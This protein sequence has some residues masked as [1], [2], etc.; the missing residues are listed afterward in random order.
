[1]SREIVPKIQV[2]TEGLGPCMLAINPAQRAYVVARVFE[3]LNQARAAEAAGYSAD[4]PDVAKST[5]YRLEHDERIQAAIAEECR[6][7]VRSEGANSIRALVRVRDDPKAKHTD[8]VK[9]AEAILDRSGLGAVSQHHHLVEHRLTEEQQDQRILALATELGLDKASAQK[10]LIDPSKAIVDAEF[11]EVAPD[12]ARERENELRRER[13]SLTPGQLAARKR[14]DRERRS[15]EGK[16]KRAAAA[17][18]ARS[19]AQ[20]DIEDF[21]D[22]GSGS[23]GLEDLLGVSANA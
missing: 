20:T 15:A 13:Q 10:L 17:E 5:G 4:T 11:E 7:L 6:K 14:Q 1:M 16:A 18:A 9:A 21:L 8:V 2:P 12:P 3:G 22:D 23:A 19:G